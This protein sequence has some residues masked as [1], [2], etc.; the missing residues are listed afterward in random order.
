MDEVPKEAKSDEISSIRYGE[1]RTSALTHGV[2]KNG[3]NQRRANEGDIREWHLDDLLSFKMSPLEVPNDRPSSELERFPEDPTAAQAALQTD[4]TTHSKHPSKAN[5]SDKMK[6][7]L[8]ILNQAIDLEVDLFMNLFIHC[9]ALVSLHTDLPAQ[10]VICADG[11]ANN[12]YDYNVKTGHQFV[13]HLT[14]I[15]PNDRSRP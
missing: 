10:L 4:P 13:S 5:S 14:A 7:A 6:F 1:P 12:L 3:E 2:D 9:T 15:A 8:I 11:G